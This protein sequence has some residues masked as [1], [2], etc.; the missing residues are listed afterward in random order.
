MRHLERER[1]ALAAARER[2]YSMPLEEMDVTDRHLFGDNVH[3]PYFERLRAEDPVHY[4]EA[5]LFG[6]YWSIT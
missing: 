3:W 2:A 5:S 1:L 4:H 6:P